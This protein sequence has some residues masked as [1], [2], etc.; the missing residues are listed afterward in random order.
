MLRAGLGPGCLP[1]EHLPFQVAG[2]LTTRTPWRW[3]P[4]GSDGSL[5]LDLLC[6]CVSAL[7]VCSGVHGPSATVMGRSPAQP[8]GLGSRSSLPFMGRDW[9]LENGKD[10][11]KVDAAE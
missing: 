11:F 5:R 8:Q 3:G 2:L 4:V 7:P 9:S 1:P 10:S 6:I